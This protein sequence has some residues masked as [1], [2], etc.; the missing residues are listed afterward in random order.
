MN[1]LNRKKK[2]M[3]EVMTALLLILLAITIIAAVFI[4][5]KQ[6]FSSLTSGS[7]TCSE[8]SFSIGDFCY[9]EQN[10]QNI[11][12]GQLELKTHLK[13]NVRNEF[14]NKVIEGFLVFIDDE[15]GNTQTIS[16]LFDTQ[17]AGFESKSLTTDFFSNTGKISNVRIAPQIKEG[18]K[19]V[20]C[21]EKQVTI[22]W[23]T[24][25]KC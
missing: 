7:N 23:S 10:I 2:G 5:N 3:S 8:I 6:I 14:Q 21:T 13:F 4:W 17:I 15:Y 11:Q 20:S 16:S 9:E 1:M 25:K 18:A 19:I 12:T 24:I 22:K